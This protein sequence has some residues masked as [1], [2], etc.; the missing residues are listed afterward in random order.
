MKTKYNKFNYLDN[1]I[2]FDRLEELGQPKTTV[3]KQSPKVVKKV[4]EMWENSQENTS[5]SLSF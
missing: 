4:S 1:I 3:H 2:F 5:T